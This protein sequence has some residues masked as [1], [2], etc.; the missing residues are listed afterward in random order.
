MKRRNFLRKSAAATA[1][2]IVIPT[3]IPSHVLGKNAPSNKIRIGQIG[4]GRIAKS[5]DLPESLKH[6]VALGVA[7]ADV[8]L[9]R[10][11]KGKEWIEKFLPQNI[12]Q[13]NM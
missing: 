7:V 8:D 10:A 6:D 11:K 3:I 2:T 9:L 1:G 4:F 13:S 12:S 5:H